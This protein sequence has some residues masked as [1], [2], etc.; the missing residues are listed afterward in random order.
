M[1]SKGNSP[2]SRDRIQVKGHDGCYVRRTGMREILGR[3]TDA[4]SVVGKERDKP[5]GDWS[6]EYQCSGCGAK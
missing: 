3:K 4:S 5:F 2:Q 1:A 6:G